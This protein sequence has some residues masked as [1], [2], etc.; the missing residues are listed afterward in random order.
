MKDLKEL[1]RLINI[2]Y[3]GDNK[4]AINDFDV[5]QAADALL[6]AN[7]KNV[8]FEEYLELH[9]AYLTQ[10]G[11]LPEQ[12]NEQLKRVKEVKSYFTND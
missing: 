10:K 4:F 2:S 1:N 11:L 9:K 5:R 8:G 12:I 3:N 6:E 7:S